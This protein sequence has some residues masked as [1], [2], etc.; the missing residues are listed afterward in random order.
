MQSNA[1]PPYLQNLWI[2]Q[3]P[4]FLD[5]GCGTRGDRIENT[6]R[7]YCEARMHLQSNTEMPA[8]AAQRHSARAS[9]TSRCLVA[10]C[11]EA[12]VEVSSH[13]EGQRRRLPVP[14]Q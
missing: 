7:A 5:L 12:P 13:D 1:G 3:L 6:E 14:S 8:S 11:S 2:G 9:L 10:I 4:N